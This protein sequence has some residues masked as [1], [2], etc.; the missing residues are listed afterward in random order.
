VAGRLALPSRAAVA[1]AALRLSAADCCLFHNVSWIQGY[2]VPCLALLG[3]WPRPA[4]R[5]AVAWLASRPRR[6]LMPRV[7]RPSIKPKRPCC[8]ARAPLHFLPRTSR[9]LTRR[10]CVIRRGMASSPKSSSSSTAAAAPRSGRSQ[11]EAASSP[12]VVGGAIWLAVGGAA[13]MGV[14]MG[15]G[16]GTMAREWWAARP[17]R[18]ELAALTEAAGRGDA[19][20]A[21]RLGLWYATAEGGVPQD[22]ERAISYYEQA[23][24]AGHIGAHVRL[25]AAYRSGLGVG[26]VDL[27]KARIHFEIAAA[28]GNAEAMFNLGV[29][30]EG[31]AEEPHAIALYRWVNNLPAYLPVHL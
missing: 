28:E 8:G 23:A 5:G 11:Q 12:V 21:H 3:A 24:V 18:A 7:P 30:C 6:V 17:A 4:A 9:V 2:H 14:G 15:G 10:V 31:E 29:L 19:A 27:V 26:D 16:L 20:A 22:L 1:V 25:G 13:V